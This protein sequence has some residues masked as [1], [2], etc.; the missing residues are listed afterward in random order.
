MKTGK[1]AKLFNRDANTI[2]DWTERYAEFFSTS[3]SSQGRSQRDYHPE[4]LIV[5]NTIRVARDR[6]NA[7]WEEIRARLANGDLETALPAESL[8]IDGNAAVTVYTQLKALEA[9]NTVLEAEVERLRLELDRERTDKERYIM[10]VGKWKALADL[11]QQMLKDK[12]DD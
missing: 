7:T 12:D 10:E 1:V 6:D 3:A 8:N 2:S 9:H 11:Y 4:D 5:L